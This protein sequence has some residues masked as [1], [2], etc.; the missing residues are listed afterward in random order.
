MEI[1]KIRGI[2]EGSLFELHR[3]AHGLLYVH[4]LDDLKGA[5]EKQGYG[6]YPITPPKNGMAAPGGKLFGCQVYVDKRVPSGQLE[7]RGA[8][9]FVLKRFVL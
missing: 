8:G 7:M 1:T 9:G 2:F 3:C 4:D 5:F 6:L